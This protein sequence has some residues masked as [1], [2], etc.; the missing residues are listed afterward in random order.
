MSYANRGSEPYNRSCRPYWSLPSS[1]SS[2]DVE[3]RISGEKAFLGELTSQLEEVEKRR[4]AV[5]EEQSQS[6]SE[7][8]QQRR[9]RE[10]REL[11]L[12]R[13]NKD[14]ST[15]KERE[16]TLHEDRCVCVCVC[17]CV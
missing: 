8:E 7:V 17:V 1:P 9:E 5:V 15:A 10:G 4:T 14:I 3:A 6:Q 16:S 11:D 12:E 2:R 13:L